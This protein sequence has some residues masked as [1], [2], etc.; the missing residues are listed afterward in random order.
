MT[1]I[2]IYK[3]VKGTFYRRCNRV[4]CCHRLNLAVT[5]SRCNNR[6]CAETRERS[7]TTAGSDYLPPRNPESLFFL[8]SALNQTHDRWPALPFSL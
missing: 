5:L 8:P 4:F 2:D 7:D 1:H 3:G 6:L